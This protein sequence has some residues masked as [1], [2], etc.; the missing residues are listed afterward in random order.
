MSLAALSGALAACGKAAD[1]SL[2]ARTDTPS[3]PV[4]A[5]PTVALATLVPE[6]YSDKPRRPSPQVTGDDVR[7]FA[8]GHNAFGLAF[9]QLLCSTIPGNLF[10]SPYSIAQAFTMLSAGAR[11]NTA[12]Q[13]AEVLHSAFPQERLHPAANALDLALTS[14]GAAQDGFQLEIANSVWGQ[15]GYTFR[16]EFLDL[17][18]ENYG[19]G[20]RTIDFRSAPEAARHKI[21]A[22]IA[23]QT[24]DKIKDL[25]PPDSIDPQTAM[26]LANA[27]YFNAK[28]HSPFK[29]YHTGVTPFHLNGGGT[30]AVPLMSQMA[31]LRFVKNGD[32]EAVSLPYEGGV[33]MLVVMPPLGSMAD[34]ERGLNAERLEAIQGRLGGNYIA[35]GLPKFACQSASVSLRPV[36]TRLGMADAFDSAKAD[37]S[38]ID[39]DHRLFLHDAYHQAMVRVDEEGT[40]AAAATAAVVE[41]AAGP[42]AQIVIDRPFIFAILDDATGALLFLGRIMNP[43]AT[44]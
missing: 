29:P 15:R 31:S 43:A 35:L 2:K 1:I 20:L 13:M 12:K 28:W 16:P 4:P 8:A 21:N 24:H 22:A 25:L 6:A 23:E 7:L 26:V 30:V 44:A 11:G 33:S 17:L 5:T 40:E 14:R 39:G 9:Y 27:I 42:S 19:A 38:G 36:F 34:F 41:P 32:Y 37:F 18:A 3:G 10:F